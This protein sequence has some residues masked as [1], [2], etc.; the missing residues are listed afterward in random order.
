MSTVFFAFLFAVLPGQAAPDSPKI[1]ALVAAEK[2]AGNDYMAIVR[3]DVRAARELKAMMDVDELKAGPDFLA[4]SGLVMNLPGYEGRLLSHEWAMTALF[5]GVPEA[6]KR[7]MLTW[8]RLQF[9]GGRYTRFG[10]I[11]GMPDKQGVRPVL[12]PDPSGPPPIVGQILEGTAPAAGANNAELKSLMESDQ[13]D[14]ENVKTPEDW[15]RMSA[16]DVPRRARVL[17]LL[18]DGKA[19]SGADLY[20]AALV[21]QH[22][23]GYRDYMLAH[24][25]T[26]AA[27]AREYKEAAWLVSRTYDRMLQNGGHAQRYGT[28]KTGGRDG[29]TF[30]VMDADLPGPSDTMRKLFRAASRAETK[31]GLEEWL[32]SVDAPAG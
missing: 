16:N 12:N 5:L 17:A 1:K 20:N 26:L 3:S 8:D 21:L 32:K 27:I 30:F 9:D 29:N 11:K 7:V 14:R 22:G 18:N 2:A 25:L 4:A 28:Q 31:K 19:T 13:K 23:N 6:G 10:Q 15:D 24:E